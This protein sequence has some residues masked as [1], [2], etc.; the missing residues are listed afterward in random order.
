MKIRKYYN[1]KISGASL[2]GKIV[3]CKNDVVKI[4][5]KIDGYSNTEENNTE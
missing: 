5:L 2:D 4:A 1:N 3:S